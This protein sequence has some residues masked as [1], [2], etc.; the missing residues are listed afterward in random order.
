MKQ[1]YVAPQLNE[2]GSVRE[3]TLANGK[4]TTIDNVTRQSKGTVDIVV[5]S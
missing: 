5:T 2:I 4:D 3:L 1:T